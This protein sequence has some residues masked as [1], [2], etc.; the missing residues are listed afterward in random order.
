MTAIAHALC[1]VFVAL[2]STNQNSSPAPSQRFDMT[3]GWVLTG[4]IA[5]PGASGAAPVAESPFGIYGNRFTAKQTATTLS[6]ELSVAVLP[7][8]VQVV[9]ALDG[10]ESKN[11]NPSQ[12]PGGEDEPIF[13]RAIWE[14]SRLIIDTR[15]TRLVDGKPQ[16]SRRVLVM[17]PNGLL[18]VERSVEGQHTTR[19]VYRR[20]K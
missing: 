1:C 14:G 12:V 7:K 19:S 10:S 5:S 15:G 6:L 11:M 8:P 9:Y 2:L 3:G 17:L 18:Q 4:M 20:E 13:S 16:T